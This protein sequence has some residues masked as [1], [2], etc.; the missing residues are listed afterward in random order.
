V[1]G[2]LSF[3]S[4]KITGMDSTT[5]YQTGGVNV[6]GSKASIYTGMIKN[7][8]ALGTFWGYKA[9]GV[10]PATGNMRYS[11][12]MMALGNA[13]PKYTYGI[14]STVHYKGLSLS[15]LFDGVHG[16]KVYNETRMEIENLT[17][18]TNES[19]AVLR[20]WKQPGDVTD[21][22]RALDN[23]STNATAA[24]LLQS[25]IASNYVEDGSFFRLRSMTLAYNL[26]ASLLKHIG[27]AGVRV[28][29]TAQNL[30]TITHY[31]G[32]YPEINGF[33][34]GTNNQAT[35]AGSTATL[36][37]LGVDNGTYPAA[38]TYTLGLNVQF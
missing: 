7:G 35:N 23:G 24:A 8:Y 18:Y 30:F 29:A 19:A 4:N 12:N 25:Q 11:D 27:I 15:L 22:P 17:G 36:M 26:D 21:I 5:S 34:Q 6:G 3:N 28:Y 37:A 10:D 13:L 16:N 20:R 31:K 9:L 2:N 33:G 1:N 32:Y 38:K 14:S